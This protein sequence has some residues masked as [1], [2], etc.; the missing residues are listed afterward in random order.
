MLF[1][2][3]YDS[4][5]QL[6]ELQEHNCQ[7]LEPT[8]KRAWVREK[9]RTMIHDN[10]RLKPRQLQFEF[11]TQYDNNKKLI[12]NSLADVKRHAPETFKHL[13]SFLLSSPLT[14]KNEGTT[15]SL[16]S[17]DGVFMRAFLCLGI[18]KDAFAHTTKVSG[19]DACH[20]KAMY[21]GAL[22]VMTALD[23]N[24]QIFPVALGVAEG[25]NSATWTW[26]LAHVKSALE[27]EDDRNG[28]FLSDREK[29]IDI[30]LNAVFP[31]A[32]HSFCVVH[33]GKNV[34][35]RFK[36]SLDGVSFK[37]A[38]AGTQKAFRDAIEEMKAVNRA[39]GLHVEQID[40]AKLLWR[41]FQP[42][43]LGT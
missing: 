36:T 33:I 43:D 14:E 12:K 9:I 16:M 42:V 32:A 10:P 8:V 2:V 24:G 31:R 28:L 21:G 27:I 30:S 41:S 7:A 18:C 37:A 5:Y 25:E 19:L 26:F 38:C 17:Q 35:T 39:A 23:G 1:R 22:L 29:G 11:L 6:V 20:I 40:L 15:T 3:N 4:V 13:G 34:K